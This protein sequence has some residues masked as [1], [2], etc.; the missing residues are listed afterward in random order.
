MS[1][2]QLKLSANQINKL[3][4]GHT[5]QVSLSQMGEGDPYFLNNDNLKK[6]HMAYNR[7]KAVRINFDDSEMEGSGL[8]GIRKGLKKATHIGNK[9]NQ[10]LHNENLD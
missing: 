5:V 7:G 2:I 4:N 8:A 1:N 3:R 9:I 10:T 6:V